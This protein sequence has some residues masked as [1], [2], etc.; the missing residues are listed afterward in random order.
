MFLA[1]TDHVKLVDYSGLDPREKVMDLGSRSFFLCPRSYS[2]AAHA[3]S[4][5]CSSAGASTVRDDREAPAA[6]G[7]PPAWLRYMPFWPTM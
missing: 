7:E 1:F 5:S 4:S 3:G 6:A 2:A